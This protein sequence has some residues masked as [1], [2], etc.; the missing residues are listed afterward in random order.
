M[1]NTVKIN[2]A[3]IIGQVI[4]GVCLD[5]IG[6]DVLILNDGELW[7]DAYHRIILAWWN[8]QGWH[9]AIK[10]EPLANYFIMERDQYLL[11][12]LKYGQYS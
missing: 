1:D 11:F 10:N 4:Q 3:L 6:K 5:A 7:I 8:D 12:L 9:I 2:Q